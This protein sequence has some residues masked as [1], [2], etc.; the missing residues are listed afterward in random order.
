MNQKQHVD[1][2]LACML[3][4]AISDYRV[5]LNASIDCIKFILHQGLA[6]RGH[7]KSSEYDNKGYFLKL[8][9]FLS[10]HND[11][12]KKVVLTNAPKKN[13]KMSSTKI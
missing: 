2:N 5:H 3:K 9:K 7:N 6:F 8:L 1:V 10:N 4:K 13:H 12:I 11:D